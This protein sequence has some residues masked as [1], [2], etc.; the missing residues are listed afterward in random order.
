MS[1]RCF[2]DVMLHAEKVRV[3]DSFFLCNYAQ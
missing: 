3:E 2:D 1:V